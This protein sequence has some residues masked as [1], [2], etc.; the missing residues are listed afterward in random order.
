MRVKEL[1]YEVELPIRQLN[2]E[3]FRQL[4]SLEPFGQGNPK[5][6][7]RTRESLRLVG[8]PRIFGH[9]H[10]AVRAESQA[11]R[12]RIKMVGWDWEKKLPFSR[13]LSKL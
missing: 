13:N 5:P 6:L 8:P 2:F 7:I 11:D 1:E 3:T 10:L 4:Q 12:S 9:G